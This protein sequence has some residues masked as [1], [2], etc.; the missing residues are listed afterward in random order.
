[1]RSEPVITPATV[2]HQP[3]HRRA[4]HRLVRLPGIHHLLLF[5]EASVPGTRGRLGRITGRP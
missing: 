2:I 5:A 1:M 4:G 3:L